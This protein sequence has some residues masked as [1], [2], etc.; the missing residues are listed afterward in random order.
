MR[1]GSQKILKCLIRPGSVHQQ[2]DTQ[3][4]GAVVPVNITRAG[5]QL[6][7]QR[8]NDRAKAPDR[9]VARRTQQIDF[10][11]CPRLVDFFRELF[12]PAG[13]IILHAVE[14]LFTSALAS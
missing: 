8:L 10:A 13:Q 6:A 14:Q 2:F 11:G 4:A 5:N 12:A 1:L 7:N 3:H 9:M